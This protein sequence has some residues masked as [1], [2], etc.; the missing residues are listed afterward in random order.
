MSISGATE[1]CSTPPSVPQSQSVPCGLLSRTHPVEQPLS[2][3]LWMFVVVGESRCAYHTWWHHT[4]M[5]MVSIN[6]AHIY[7]VKASH[8]ITPKLNKVGIFNPARWAQQ[9]RKLDYLMTSNTI[10]NTEP[11]PSQQIG[12]G[13]WVK[14]KCQEWLED[15][16]LIS[17]PQGW[18][19]IT[20][21]AKL[22]VKSF[23]EYQDC[24]LGHVQVKPSIRYPSRDAQWEA[25]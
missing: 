20:Q 22:Q 6:S 19:A 24:S 9:E 11:T 23:I 21:M 14:E 4:W 2:G 3:T 1:D 13:A 12:G 7:L 8:M 25:G 5:E 17:Q 16:G 18:I 15:L 10:S